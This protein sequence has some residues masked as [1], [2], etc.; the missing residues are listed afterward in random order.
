MK[1]QNLL[2]E[3]QVENILDDRIDENGWLLQLSPGI[4]NSID[5]DFSFPFYEEGKKLW[6][7]YKPILKNIICDKT[8]NSIKPEVDE[9]LLGNVR[10]VIFVIYFEL[11][12]THN[13]SAAIAIPLIAIVLKRKLQLFCAE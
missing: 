13:V 6:N 11:T 2:T 8:R 3:Q 10:E 4:R 9:G 7:E 5:N 1:T 12:N